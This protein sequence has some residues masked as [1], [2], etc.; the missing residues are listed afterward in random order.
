MFQGIPVDMVAGTSMGSFVG[1]ALA[2]YGDVS[3]MC[4]K[5]REWSWVRIL[6]SK[7]HKNLVYYKSRR[8]WTQKYTWHWYGTIWNVHNL[9]VCCLF[10]SLLVC[11]LG[12]LQACLL[13]YSVGF[14]DNLFVF[15]FLTCLVL[16]FVL[17][18]QPTWRP[19]LLYF[20][21]LSFSSEVSN[22]LT[23]PS[24]FVVGLHRI[25]R[26]YSLK[27]STSPTHSHQCSQVWTCYG[28]QTFGD[29][30][31]STAIHCLNYIC[32]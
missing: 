19:R 7:L 18:Y 14:L 4:Q 27:Y 22:K 32:L 1:A 10:V 17:S 12:W 23:N 29:W 24:P 5:V 28:W 26:L 25:W 15:L 16:D 21:F 13:A 3:K 11:F 30:I 9:L 31:V 6:N 20:C 2:E 8:L